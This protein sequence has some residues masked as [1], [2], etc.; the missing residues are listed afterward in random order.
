MLLDAI[1]FAIAF[2]VA[3]NDCR[4]GLKNIVAVVSAVVWGYFSSNPMLDYQF[5]TAGGGS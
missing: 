4:Y 5:L 2:A 1:V 3:A